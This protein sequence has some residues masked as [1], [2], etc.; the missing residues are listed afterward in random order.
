MRQM[1][2]FDRAIDGQY[3]EQARAERDA[4]VV[5]AQAARPRESDPP[6]NRA[7]VSLRPPESGRRSGAAADRSSDWGDDGPTLVQSSSEARRLLDAGQ[8]DE[9]GGNAV[10]LASVE[11]ASVELASAEVASADGAA[12]EVAAPRPS[13]ASD[14]PTEKGIRAVMGSEVVETE[15]LVALPR[16]VAAAILDQDSDTTVKVSYG[17]AKAASVA[18][19]LGEV[20]PPDSSVPPVDSKRVRRSAD[21]RGGAAGTLDYRTEANVVTDYAQRLAV[22]A[23]MAADVAGYASDAADLATEAARQAARGDAV[24]AAG[25]AEQAQQVLDA[26]ERGSVPRRRRGQAGADAPFLTGEQFVT[27]AVVFAVAIIASTALA[28]VLS[29]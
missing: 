18:E 9:A 6:S 5:E 25:Y 26:I 27:L 7:P 24:A 21:T 16:E 15:T 29:G 14:A 20:A 13:I 8:L 28:V 3:A 19:R 22:K 2:W 17:V 12:A 1:R 23:S 4:R 10:E 11:L